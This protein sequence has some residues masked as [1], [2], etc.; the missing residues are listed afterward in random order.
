M[1]DLLFNSRLLG[2]MSEHA[3][4][5]EEEM[6][7][8]DDW[9]KGKC[10]ANT[11]MMHHMSESTVNRIRRRLRQKYDGIQGYANLPPRK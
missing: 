4:L 6:T 1:N 9:S 5:T 7:V 3:C 10:I 8:L 11:S 2:A